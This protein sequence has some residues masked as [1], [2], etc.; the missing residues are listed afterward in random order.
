MS[1]IDIFRKGLG[2]V[3]M[4]MGASSSQALKKKPAEAPAAKPGPPR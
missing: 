4:A 2:Y 1:L 3:L